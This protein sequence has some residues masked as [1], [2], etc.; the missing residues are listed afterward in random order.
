[1][2]PN[3]VVWEFRGTHMVYSRGCD[4]CGVIVMRYIDFFRYW[5]AER[6]IISWI[7]HSIAEISG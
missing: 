1:L 2:N 5:L 6:E 3:Y 4:P 7:A